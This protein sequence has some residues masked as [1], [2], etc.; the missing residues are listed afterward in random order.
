MSQLEMLNASEERP[1]L[2]HWA[3]TRIIDTIEF[4][5]ANLTDR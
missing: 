1:N 5:E 2:F 3:R 4:V